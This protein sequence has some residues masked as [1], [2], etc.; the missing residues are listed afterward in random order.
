QVLVA[1]QRDPAWKAARGVL[2]IRPWSEAQ[3]ACGVEPAA[4]YRRHAFLRSA[5]LDRA[6]GDDRIAEIG[7]LAPVQR[8][9]GIE[10]LQAAHEQRRETDSVDPVRNPNR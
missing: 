1:G 4:E 9:C 7:L 2:A 8:G 10:D 3:I 5:V 6:H